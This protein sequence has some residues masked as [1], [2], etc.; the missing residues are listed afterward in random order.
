MA[1]RSNIE[2]AYGDRVVA[3]IY[4]HY[5]GYPLNRLPELNHFFHEVKERLKDTRFSD[6]SYLAA[7]Y[8]VWYTQLREYSRVVGLDFLG[9]GVAVENAGDSEY[10]YRVHCDKLDENGFPTV[11]YRKC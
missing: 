6:P 9:I 1:T 4:V 5:D 11:S 3:N 10:I 8:I 7:K 2:F